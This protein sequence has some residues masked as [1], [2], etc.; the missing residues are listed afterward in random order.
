MCLFELC[1]LIRW[2]RESALSLSLSGRS[3]GN[4]IASLPPT[5]SFTFALFTLSLPCSVSPSHPISDLTLNPNSHPP[6]S[7]SRLF[8]SR[9]LSSSPSLHSTP[10]LVIPST[11]PTMSSN[12]QVKKICCSQSPHP[13]TLARAAPVLRVPS[14][15]P[16]PSPPP[17]LTFLPIHVQQMAHHFLSFSF[18]LV[19][20][21]VPVS[22]HRCWSCST[23]RSEPL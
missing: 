5:L 2:E 15:H 10:N 13:R 22:R 23:A 19:S 20:A 21:L 8:P 6:F 4:R 14:S 12:T 11:P 3:A 17:S 9:H 18:P 16:I 1:V 7:I